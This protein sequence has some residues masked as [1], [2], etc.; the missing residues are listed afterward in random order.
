MNYNKNK[1]ESKTNTLLPTSS[2][3]SSPSLFLLSFKISR[4]L[5]KD[6]LQDQAFFLGSHKKLVM[7]VMVNNQSLFLLLFLSLAG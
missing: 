7:M 1:V 5:K 6:K 3:Y 2:R 4:N